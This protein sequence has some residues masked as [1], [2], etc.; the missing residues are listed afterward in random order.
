MIPMAI[1]LKEA[2]AMDGGSEIKQYDEQGRVI[3]TLKLQIGIR[4]DI[5]IKPHLTVWYD[6]DG[7]VSY[8]EY[9]RSEYGMLSEYW[10]ET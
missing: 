3:Y 4:M 10:V 6:A 1:L 9:R 7:N 5:L 2:T 8:H